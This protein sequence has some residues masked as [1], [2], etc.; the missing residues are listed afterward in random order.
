MYICLCDYVCIY[1]DKKDLGISKYTQNSESSLIFM[2]F[3]KHWH[4]CQCF[5]QFPKQ[6]V[7]V[8]GPFVY[9]IYLLNSS[10]TIGVNT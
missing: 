5:F 1:C 4:I 2:P 10:N 7:G 3:L 8:F 9:L 6:G